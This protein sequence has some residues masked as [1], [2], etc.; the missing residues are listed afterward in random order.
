MA[1]RTGEVSE[2]RLAPALSGLLL[3]WAA[4]T[5]R[6]WHVPLHRLPKSIRVVREVRIPTM[7]S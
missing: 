4:F 7:N 5:L 2:K 3:L 1:G 6:C